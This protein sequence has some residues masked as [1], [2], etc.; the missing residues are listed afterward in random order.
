MKSVLIISFSG[1]GNTQF[2]VDAVIK[3]LI[4]KGVTASSYPLE[5]LDNLKNMDEL[6]AVDLIGIAF[7]VHAFNPAPLVEK[8][9]NNLPQTITKKCFI[10]KTS[11]SPFAMGGTTTKLKAILEKRNWLLKYEALVP[12]PSNFLIRYSDEFIK[13]NAGMAIKQADKIASDLIRENW[14]IIKPER[15]IFLLGAVARMERI[16][17]IFYGRYLKVGPNCIKCGKCVKNCPT[18]NIKFS[19]GKFSFGWKCT[20]CMR[21]SFECPVQAY[22]HKH[23]GRLVSVKPP[24]NLVSILNN[25]AIKEADITDDK[26]PNMKDFRRFWFKAGVLD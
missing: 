19:D 13:L 2:V 20:F 9:I 14:K 24:Y 15:G 16:G 17:A 12:M 3:S 22:S 21:C 5:K 11:G 7:P 4:K 6:M 25:P 23:F 8:V 18:R 26:I 10:I 1:T